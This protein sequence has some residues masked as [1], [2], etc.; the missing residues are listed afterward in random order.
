MER[1]VAS[2]T[3]VYR[4]TETAQPAK[5]RFTVTTPTYPAPLPRARRFRGWHAL[6]IFVAANALSVLPAGFNGDE[7]FYN[8]FSR[9][10][11]APPDWLFPPMWLVLNVTSL[12]AL[13]RVANRGVRNRAR[14]A[15]L[16]LEAAG[17]VLFAVFN[18]LYFGLDSPVLGALVTALGLLVGALSFLCCLRTERRAAWLILPRVLW[19]GLAT[20]VSV[21]VALNN[22]DPF[23]QASGF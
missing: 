11:A 13:A 14:T 5:R 19:L 15:V 1:R 8:S 16:G 3:P 12:V 18:T 4:Y 10:A 2:D 6:L 17:W 21:W 7:A 20:Y 22:A 9:P 23:L